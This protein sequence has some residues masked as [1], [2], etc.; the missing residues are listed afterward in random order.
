MGGGTATILSKTIK[1]L[2][3]L[4]F[5]SV[6]VAMV[7]QSPVMAIAQNVD[8][9]TAVNKTSQVNIIDFEPSVDLSTIQEYITKN[10]FQNLKS[11]SIVADLDTDK[12]N[13]PVVVDLD[14]KD[15]NKTKESIKLQK[16]AILEALKQA[17]IDS[18][19]PKIKQKYYRQELLKEFQNSS[20]S[21]ATDSNSKINKVE[22]P[23]ESD[24]L[25]Y[26]DNGVLPAKPVVESEVRAKAKELGLKEEYVKYAMDG[27]GKQ[28]NSRPE[29]IE[30][31]MTPEQKFERE[32]AKAE[33]KLQEDLIAQ[34][35]AT[36]ITK[37]I[38]ESDNIDNI[39][40][41]Q[42][43]FYTNVG[44]KNAV[45]TSTKAKK[46]H[47]TQGD[48][49]LE[50]KLKLKSPLTRGGNEVDGVD[51]KTNN[52][53][54]LEDNIK[55]TTSQDITA[56]FNVSEAEKKVTKDKQLKEKQEYLERSKKSKQYHNQMEV[57][58]LRA[59]GINV[60]SV[61]E[62]AKETKS[63]K[64]GVLE[65][66]LKLGSVSAE[67]KGLN[68]SANALIIYAA[69]N[70]NLAFTFGSNYQSLS[71]LNTTNGSYYNQRLWFDNSTNQIKLNGSNNQCLD[72]YG[73]V[74]AGNRIGLWDC[75]SGNNQ[76]WIF[77]E[78]GRLVPKYNQDMCIDSRGG[79]Y[80]GA[81]LL[82]WYCHNG[83]N[84]KYRAGYNN[85]GF[86]NGMTIWATVGEYIF[87]L[88]KSRSQAG[89]S[90]IELWNTYG[91]GVHNTFGKWDYV[92]QSCT[93]NHT[94]NGLFENANN[95]TTSNNICDNDRIQV[96]SPDDFWT[97]IKST[98]SFKKVSTFLSKQDWDYRTYLISFV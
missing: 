62:E 98:S 55:Q 26:E 88:P 85:F 53:K 75:H 49:T 44:D 20:S 84:Q 19:K 27:V 97:S 67:A 91:I 87:S 61:D 10:K 15:Q 34:T 89:H 94:I 14:L 28:A 82:I 76:K 77:D 4:A 36:Q 21:S 74:G 11:A 72:V 68:N 38:K 30:R 57:E 66:L 83:G 90:Y 7:V 65:N 12:Y 48:K 13:L 59:E 81:D 54:K 18:K 37:L 47:K 69:D 41:S 52:S 45:N 73:G 79:L 56:M 63:G 33:A 23:S 29:D 42:L 70:N 80:N 50:K 1:L 86:T 17:K 46:S 60:Q 93:S 5:S 8:S 78:T 9:I 6:M 71:Y 96:D 16:K 40:V 92:D 35:D 58:M 64:V 24:L 51:P 22:L 32:T 31:V 39:K 2:S 25:F 43:T 95:L 3:T